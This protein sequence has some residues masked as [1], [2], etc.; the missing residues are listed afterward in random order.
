[1]WEVHSIAVGCLSLEGLFSTVAL[2]YTLSRVEVVGDSTQFNCSGVGTGEA[3]GPVA[4][5]TSEHGGR[6]PQQ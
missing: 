5:P 2:R 1:M 6:P 3:R 4:L